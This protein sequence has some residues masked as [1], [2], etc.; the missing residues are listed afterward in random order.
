M[1]R[2]GQV[3]RIWDS[4]TLHEPSSRST[5]CGPIRRVDARP[6][7]CTQPLPPLQIPCVDINASAHACT[8]GAGRESCGRHCRRKARG[9]GQS[10]LPPLC[11]LSRLLMALL[12]HP[13]ISSAALC[14]S[15]WPRCAT[16]F[17]AWTARA[18]GRRI[19]VPRH[20]RDA[21]DIRCRMGYLFSSCSWGDRA[22]NGKTVRR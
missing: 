12:P 13:L 15:T 5:Q 21:W 1:R 10:A 9:C 14:R 17:D 3:T 16:L 4:T 18:A 20:V 19:S 22:E 7:K 2:C 6:D 11:S 8:Y